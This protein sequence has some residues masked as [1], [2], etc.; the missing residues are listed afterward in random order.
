[1]TAKQ[2]SATNVKVYSL[3]YERRLQE[4]FFHPVF[5]I[6][7]GFLSI[8]HVKEYDFNQLKNERK[9]D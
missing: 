7:L 1:M 9:K 2:F 4:R 5:I 8:E 3:P 6:N